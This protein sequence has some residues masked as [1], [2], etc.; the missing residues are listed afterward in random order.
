MFTMGDYILVTARG[1]ESFIRASEDFRDAKDYHE[2]ARF[3]FKQQDG[4]FSYE[5]SFVSKEEYEKFEK[6]IMEALAW[7]KAKYRKVYGW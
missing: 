5:R 6:G 2:M 3:V 1:Q 7:L 4:I